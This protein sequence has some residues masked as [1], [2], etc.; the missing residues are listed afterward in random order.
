MRARFFSKPFLYFF[1]V[2]PDCRG[3]TINLVSGQF[4]KITPP[5]DWRIEEAAQDPRG[6]VAFFSPNSVAQIRVL[7]KAVDLTDYDSL[8]NDLQAREKELGISPNVEMISFKGIPAVKRVATVTVSNTTI[9]FL[10]IDFLTGKISH[11]IQ[12]SSTPADFEKE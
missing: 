7:A 1:H 11:N 9:K 12:Y 3:D 2:K 10:W 5:Q 4:F 8:L 6:K